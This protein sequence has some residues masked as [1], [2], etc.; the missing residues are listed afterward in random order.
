MKALK[1][2]KGVRILENY[3]YHDDE[4]INEVQVQPIIVHEVREVWTGKD[5]HWNLKSQ[6][7]FAHLNETVILWEFNSWIG[8]FVFNCAVS[9]LS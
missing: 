5:Q 4:Q 7:D 2:K 3:F 8:P 1:C 9:Q 6:K